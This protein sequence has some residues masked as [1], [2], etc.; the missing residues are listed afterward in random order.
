MF[1]CLIKLQSSEQSFVFSFILV[2]KKQSCMLLNPDAMNKPGSKTFQHNCNTVIIF[3]R[4]ITHGSLKKSLKRVGVWNGIKTFFFPFLA[5]PAFFFWRKKDQIT[6]AT[7][8]TR[9]HCCGNIF[10]HMQF[11]FCSKYF[12]L[13]SIIFGKQCFCIWCVWMPLKCYN[14]QLY[15]CQ[16]PQKIPLVDL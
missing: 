8:Q 3:V 7:S 13:G 15:P 5:F 9:K 10:V 12:K 2:T 14:M 6:H 4:T 11:I 16:V 1:S